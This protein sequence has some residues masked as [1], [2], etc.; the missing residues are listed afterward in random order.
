MSTDFRK[1]RENIYPITIYLN[2]F[3]M[4]KGAE[5]TFAFLSTIQQNCQGSE[6]KLGRNH[7]CEDQE[8][9]SANNKEKDLNF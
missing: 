5:I 8:N 9:L 2:W 4:A 1:E 6:A 7:S 3:L